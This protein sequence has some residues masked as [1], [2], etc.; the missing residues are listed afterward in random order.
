M[1]LKKFSAYFFLILFASISLFAQENQTTVFQSGNAN[2]SEILQIIQGAMDQNPSN[3]SLIEQFGEH[4]IVKVSQ[5]IHQKRE[6]NTGI[7][8]QDGNLNEAI[9]EQIG[10]SNISNITQEGSENFTKIQQ[11][12]NQNL[13]EISLIGNNN[14]YTLIQSGNGNQVIENYIAD[15]LN[16]S[17]IQDGNNN[18]LNSNS[19][20]TFLINN[21]KI[22]QKGNGIK[23]ILNSSF[24]P[25][26]TQ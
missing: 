13:A 21:M 11:E 7:I 6:T 12:G 17:I 20:K 8:L 26:F 1:E 16:I 14:Q 10:V 3:N 22:V 24:L 18:V 25:V 5:S 19:T 4:N 23:M 2:I 15:N 9:L